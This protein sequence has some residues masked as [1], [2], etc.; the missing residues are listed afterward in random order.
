MRADLLG[1]DLVPGLRGTSVCAAAATVPAHEAASNGFVARNLDRG[2]RAEASERPGERLI[3]VVRAARFRRSPGRLR[4]RQRLPY[5][6]IAGSEVALAAP[7][8]HAG[9][10]GQEGPFI[11]LVSHVLCPVQVTD[12]S[13]TNMDTSGS[14]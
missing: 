8:A 13:V 1:A 7:E 6:S 3:V 11:Q 12:H 2:F 14:S 5:A 4:H 10:H 9:G